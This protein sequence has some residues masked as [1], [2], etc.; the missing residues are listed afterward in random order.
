MLT[1]GLSAHLYTPYAFPK[2]AFEVGEMKRR[3]RWPG[4]IWARTRACFF[5]PSAQATRPLPMAS[6]RDS[7][8]LVLSPTSFDAFQRRRPTSMPSNR[9]R[10]ISIVAACFTVSPRFCRPHP[11]H[12]PRSTVRPLAFDA[13]PPRQSARTPARLARSGRSRRRRADQDSRV[14]RAAAEITRT[15]TTLQACSARRL[16]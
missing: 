6:K 4:L 7:K 3:Y 14:G 1:V 13:S 10:T 5:F 9:A 12:R 11:S 16:W 2:H 15:A 8:E